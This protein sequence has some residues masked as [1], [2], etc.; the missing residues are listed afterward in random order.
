MSDIDISQAEADALAAM[1][2]IRVDDKVWTL[3]DNGG[4]IA[5]PLVSRSEREEFV[6]DV[7]RTRIKLEKGTYNNRGRKV[8]VLARLDFGGPPHRNP[9]GEEIGPLHL[10]VYREG[11]GD[12]WAFPPPP[13]F[14]PDTDDRWVMLNSFMDYC[15]I[16][17]PPLIER[18]IFT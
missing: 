9:D 8:V 14:F 12:K 4:K 3:P 11:Y 5:I 16:V 1:E 2:K 17:D 7:H 6:L 13:E 10:H 18:G 15:R